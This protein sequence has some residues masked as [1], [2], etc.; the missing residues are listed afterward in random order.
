MRCC[1]RP[2][3][4]CRQD[5]H[6]APRYEAFEASAS[7]ADGRASR[8][9]PAGTVARGWLRDDEALYTGKIDGQPVD[10][11]PFAIAH[12]DLKR[13]QERFTHLLH[14]VPRTARRRQ[15]HGGAAR[16]APG[17][18]LSTRIGCAR[19]ASATSSTS[20]TNGFGAMQ[21]YAEQVPVRDRWLIAAYV[22]ALQYSQNASVN[23][24]PR[25]PR[26]LDGKPAASHRR[27]AAALTA[28]ERQQAEGRRQKQRGD[29]KHI[30]HPKRSAASSGSAWAPRCSASSATDRRLPDG[31]AGALLP[32][33]SRRLHVRLRHRARQHGAADG[34]APVGRRLGPRDSPSARGRGAHDA[35]HGAAVPADRVRHARPLSLVASRGRRRRSGARNGRRRIST[36]RS[37]I[38][39]QVVFFRDLDR[40][41]PAADVVVGRAGSLGRP[42]A[43]R[44][45]SRSC[46]APGSSSTASPSP[47]RWSTG[48]C[49]STRTGSRRCGD[50]CTWSARG[51][52]R[53]P[54]RS[55]ILIMLSQIAP[56]NRIVTSHHLHD[57]GKLLFAFLM[58]HAYLSFSQFLIIWS[59]NLAEEIPHYL[60]RWDSGYQYVSIFMIVRPLRG[61]V[62]A[63][64]VARH[65][66]RLPRAAA[67]RDVASV[68]APRRLLLARGAG[69]PQRG[70]QRR[71]SSTSRRRLPSAA[72]S[73][74]SL[75]RT[76]GSTRCCR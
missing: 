4:G 40:D 20:I 61:A 19:S 38:I 69:V 44:A 52:R 8:T 14:A 36:R 15:R 28:G 56:L 39:R 63:A 27:G 2:A 46:R 5:M 33:V 49:R 70:P 24:V 37:S 65:Q 12:D 54:L 16:A 59:A 55:S 72:C 9:A 73:W 53:W 1:G 60:I 32:G 7:F 68:R 48:R 62:R 67:D 10:A 42:G 58:L 71:A 29:W 41:Q 3:A 64:A 31:R 57:L 76:C 21:G 35:D 50:R 51:C 25:T 47:S 30:N 75:P 18:Q 26:R 11:I 22:R 13:G 23:D 6:D 43:G 66:A 74:R 45:S 34:S 17:G